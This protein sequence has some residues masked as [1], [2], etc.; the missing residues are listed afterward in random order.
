MSHFT[1]MLK[2]T[3]ER[4]ARHD[5]NVETAVAKMLAPF[6][7]NNMG[8]CPKEFL[9]FH[10]DEDSE[11]DA[12]T[13]KRGYWENP[14]KTWDWY[15]IGGR[16]SGFFPVKASVVPELGE[17]SLMSREA[18]EEGKADICRV[19]DLDMDKI[20]TET[21]EQTEEFWE[22]WDRFKRG[23][24]PTRGDG[25][26]D[27][28]FRHNVRSRA[29]DLGLLRVIRIDKTNKESAP[30][31]W[32][33]DNAEW[34]KCADSRRTWLDALSPIGREEFLAQF[35]DSFCPVTA[36]AALDDDGWHAPGKMGWFGCSSD[37][38]EQKTAHDKEFVRRFIK[39]ATPDTTLVIVD[40]HI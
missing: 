8:D 33:T 2:I 40:C 22:K 39:Q 17:Q 29:M 31:G 34:K 30:E 27:P 10:E 4:L 16:W 28:W 21:R 3:P 25:R 7:E 36:Y 6:Q 18:P 23:D 35:I 19:G 32:I 11:V 13:G 12:E 15:Q 26:P 1:V 5:G 9:E 14:N 37:T 20:A 24:I 38:P